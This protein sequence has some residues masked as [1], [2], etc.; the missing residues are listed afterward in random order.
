MLIVLVEDDEILRRDMV[1]ILTRR[2]YQ[3][4][5]VKSYKEAEK[6][7]ME[8]IEADLYL[9][10]VMLP[11]KSGFVLCQRIR[12]FCDTPIIFLT[13]CSDEAS[14]VKGLDMGGDDYVTKPFRVAEL[15]SRIS[16]NLRRVGRKEEE[17]IL[18]SG[19]LK[20]C[21][22][23]HKLFRRQGEKWGEVKLSK[24]EWMLLEYMMLHQGRVLKREQILAHIWDEQGNFVE[25]NT[26][27]VTLSRLRKKVGD[28]ENQ[29][30]WDVVCV[31]VCG[32]AIWFRCRKLV[33]RKGREGHM[34]ERKV[35][36]GSKIAAGG[37]GVC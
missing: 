36:S 6:A 31:C 20:L 5:A 22:E 17:G 13:A 8:G 12:T 19:D 25:D 23:S 11:D 3:V 21:R 33:Y 27:S 2:D 35:L 14:V 15:L 34:K 32:T 18:L 7:F 1:E 30:Y 9:I 26:L 29:P 16:D 4:K 10:D 24:T 28:Y 37:Q